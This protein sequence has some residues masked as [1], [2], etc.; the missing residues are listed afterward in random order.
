MEIFYLHFKDIKLYNF[1]IKKTIKPK[2]SEIREAGEG[3]CQ[4]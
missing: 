1:I 3:H 4:I 2:Y